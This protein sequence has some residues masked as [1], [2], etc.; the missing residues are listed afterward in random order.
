[1]P[2]VRRV[3]MLG[4]GRREGAQARTARRLTTWATVSLVGR[5]EESGTAALAVLL[6][7]GLRRRE[8]CVGCVD[9]EMNE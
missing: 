3:G 8:V 1:M 6:F 2:V 5:R 4:G 7:T 9:A